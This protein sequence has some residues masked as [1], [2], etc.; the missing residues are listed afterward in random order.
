MAIRHVGA[1]H[2][3][4]PLSSTS[5]FGAGQVTYVGQDADITGRGA[6]ALNLQQKFQPP[7]AAP[8]ILHMHT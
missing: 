3:P 7:A 5:F 6:P 4:H 2:L 1:R 8:W